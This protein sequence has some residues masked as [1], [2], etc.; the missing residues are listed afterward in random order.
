MAKKIL[1]WLG[2]CLCFSPMVFVLVAAGYSIGWVEFGRV[3]LV[4][5]L[6]IVVVG[7]VMWLGKWMI[8]ESFKQGR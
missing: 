5:L 8:D 3:V 4:T 2:V 1:R 6:V 7:G